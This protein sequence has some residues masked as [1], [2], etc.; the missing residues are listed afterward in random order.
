MT[1]NQHRLL[2]HR[3]PRRGRTI[4][5]MLSVA[6]ALFAIALLVTPW[7]QSSAASGRVIAYAALERQQSIDAPVEGR[8]SEWRVIEG[9][10]V[11]E[12][13][14]LVVVSD[15][16]PA[17]VDRL[18]DERRALEARAEAA[19]ARVASIELRVDSLRSSGESAVGAADARVRMARDRILAA[20]QSLQAS[21]AARET[22]ELN[23]DRVRALFE[24][25]LQSKRALELAELEVV[26]TTTDAA[27]ADSILSAARVEESALSADR[28]KVS[29][30]AAALVDDA[31]A[32][33]SSAA[34]EVASADAEIARVQVRLARQTAQEVRAPRDGS[35]LRILAKQGGQYVKSGEPLAL[36]VPDTLDRAVELWVDGNDINL[37]REGGPVR[38]QFEG[39]P[40]VQFSGWPSLAAGTYGAKVA[41]VDAQGDANGRFRVVAVPDPEDHPWP[42][43]ALLRQGT[44]AHGLLLM[45]RVSLGYELW[46]RA[47]GF[48]LEWVDGGSKDAGA[49]GDGKGKGD[50]K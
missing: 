18:R 50:R 49:S 24:E 23:V 7:Q 25:G 16:D 48:P 4:F 38:L 12:G 5:R 15:N 8:V 34:A 9:Q 19:R 26:R 39:W 1:R 45:A 47:N 40:A 35:I 21:V 10:H 37:V 6:L 46:R 27:R 13:D 33:R 41:V 42:E 3:A 14:V 30:D 43:P 44:R 29:N 32:S 2:P 11:R 20:E 28:T 36:L 31:N 17:L 22:A